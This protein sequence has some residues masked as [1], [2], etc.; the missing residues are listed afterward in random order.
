MLQR[1]KV[2]AKPYS[3]SVDTH[4]QGQ[5]FAFETMIECYAGIILNQINAW[6][7]LNVMMALKEQSKKKNSDVWGWKY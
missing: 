6:I 5:R 1:K 4:L 2:K 3:S 7:K